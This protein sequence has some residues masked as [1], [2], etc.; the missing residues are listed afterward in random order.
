MIQFEGD[1]R[2]ED[3]TGVRRQSGFLGGVGNGWRYLSNVRG[4]RIRLG[5]VRGQVVRLQVRRKRER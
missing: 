4:D 5:G 3:R 2:G 1:L